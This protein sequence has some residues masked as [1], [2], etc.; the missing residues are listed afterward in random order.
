AVFQ[1]PG[2]DAGRLLGPH[3][4]QL[5]LAR[6]VVVALQSARAAGR[7]ADG[8]DIDD[9]VVLRV[10]GDEAR[11]AGAGIGAVGQ[12]DDAPFR[13]R[14][15]RD[16]GV[17]LLRAVDAVGVLVVDVDAVELRGLLV[18]DRRP[19]GAAVQRDVG[20]AV[21]A[22]DHALRVFRIDPEVV[23]VAVPRRDLAEG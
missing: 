5:Q 11:L 22:L 21:V 17:V 2:R 8:A 14:R 13:R 16:R 10:H 4:D 12:G 1:V 6:A 15:H 20:A 3:V 18:V 19:R 7:G 23:V 9:V